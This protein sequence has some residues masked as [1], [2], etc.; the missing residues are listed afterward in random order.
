M[1]PLFISAGCGLD[2]TVFAAELTRVGF[3]DPTPARRKME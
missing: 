1:S 2:C 3:S